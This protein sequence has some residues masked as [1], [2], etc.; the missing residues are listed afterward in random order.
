MLRTIMHDQLSKLFEEIKQNESVLCDQIAAIR[1]KEA[2][3]IIEVASA[4]LSLSV[5]AVDGGLISFTMHGMDILLIRS[6]GVNF[7]YENSSLKN[8]SY[9]PEKHPEPMIEF[10]NALDEYDIGV[11]K[12]LTRLKS[13]LTCAIEVIEKYKPDLML[14]DGSLLPLPTDKPNTESELKELYEEVLSLYNKLFD[15]CSSINC[16]LCGIIKDSRSKRLSKTFGIN[17][18]DS[19]L[20]NYLLSKGE[21]TNF[22]VYGKNEI[23]NSEKIKFFYIKPS[24]EDIPL[25]VEFLDQNNSEQI[26]PSLIYSLS[27][28]S[29]SFAYP[30]I[31]IEADLCAALDEKEAE[32]IR[33]FLPSKALRRD[34]RP[35]R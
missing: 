18:S 11:Y 26:I 15:L 4:N 34:S 19:I 16:Q 7:I 23:K 6:A 24:E 14:I 28:I 31:L 3:S 1:K 29:S 8:H 27:A 33:S 35:F 30:A 32:K 9:Y 2:Q 5:C 20:C 10:R 21:R 13:E 17:C 12:S 25:R 22:F